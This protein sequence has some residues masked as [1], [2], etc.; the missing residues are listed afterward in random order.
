[1]FDFRFSGFL[2]LCRLYIWLNEGFV[3]MILCIVVCVVIL[4]GECGVGLVLCV[5]DLVFVLVLEDDVVVVC[6]VCIGV[7]LVVKFVSNM[8]LLSVVLDSNV[9]MVFNLVFRLV[10]VS[11]G[12][13]GKI[14]KI[15]DLVYFFKVG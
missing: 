8:M 14:G 13:Y 11:V 2:V 6:V 15:N 9:V 3:G 4:W 12:D 5:V 10:G 7:R 1:M